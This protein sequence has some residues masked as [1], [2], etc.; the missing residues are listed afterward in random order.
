MLCHL[1]TGEREDLVVGAGNGYEAC[2]KLCR[3]WGPATSGRKRNLPRAI[4]NPERCKAWAAVRPAIEQLEDLVRRYEA[5]RSASGT[6]ELLSDGIKSASLELVVPNDLEKHLILNKNRLTTYD[7]MKQEV[8]LVVE[9]SV[10]SKASVTRPGQASSS[11]GPEPMDVDSITQWI[12]SLVK[13]QAKGKGEGKSKG[14]EKGKGKGKDSS[15]GS[16]GSNPNRDKDIVC[17]NC[18]KKGHRQAG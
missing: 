18:G 11:S 6:R 4:L 3:R 15:K 2:R 9:P 1:C 14:K 8:E 17:H 10:G 7:L 13:G 16:N 5:G 12:A